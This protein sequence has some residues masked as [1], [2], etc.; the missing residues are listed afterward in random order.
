MVEN[1]PYCFSPAVVA[2]AQA[3]Q[4]YLTEQHMLL[5]DV[6]ELLMDGRSPR[7]DATADTCRRVLRNMD[8]EAVLIRAHREFF[9]ELYAALYREPIAAARGARLLARQGSVAAGHG[10]SRRSPSGRRDPVSSA[11][12]PRQQWPT[13]PS[14]RQRQGLVLLN[15]L[16]QQKRQLQRQLQ[17]QQQRR[18]RSPLSPQRPQS[19]ADDDA[20]SPLLTDRP[21][22]DRSP[23]TPGTVIIDVEWR[24]DAATRAH[25]SSD[26][27]PNNRTLTRSV[28]TEHT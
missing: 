25:F 13:G 15:Q 8:S 3:L 4:R 20:T 16:E 12:G 2:I 1:V 28:R 22:R 6:R 24:G 19:T 7:P 18:C 10:R 21:P 26:S 17:Q 14:P 23:S 27:K 9:A 11:C 5:Q